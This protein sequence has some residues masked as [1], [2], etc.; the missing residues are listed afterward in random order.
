MQADIVS[1][2]VLITG[3]DSFT[4]RHLS[5]FL[6]AKGFDVYGTKMSASSSQK[7]FKCDITDRHAIEKVVGKTKPN[8]VIHL[9]GISFVGH[10]DI[11]AFY[12]INTIGTCNLLESLAKSGL[13]F[14]KVV[15]ASSATVYGNTG[16]EVLDESLCPSPMNH[17]G[18]SKLAMEFKAKLFFSRLP[19]IIA[20]PFNYTGVGQPEQFLIP[21][22]VTHFAKKE[23]TIELGNLNVEREFNDVEF[24]CAVYHGLLECKNSSEIVNICSGRGVSLMEI[25][26]AARKITG[27]EIEIKIN[28]LFVRK[29]ELKRLV[30]SRDKLFGIIGECE[31][32]GIEET[33][34]RMLVAKNPH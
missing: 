17:Y 24:A 21:K 9:A 14:D 15:L 1:K 29:G 12:K 26:D 4:G 33:L 32:L 10:G 19:I 34:K 20:R 6:S 13:C 25:M 16:L 8:F 27:H 11:E 2:K 28:P 3:I 7:V 31:Q 18:I 5:A 22:I 30:G 23:K